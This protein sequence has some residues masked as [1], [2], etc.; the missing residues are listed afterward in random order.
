MSEKN[1]QLITEKQEENDCSV[2]GKKHAC[3][4]FL[5][6]ENAMMHMDTDN[7]RA[8]RT[9][10]ICCATFIIITLIFVFAYT[11]RMNSFL[12]TINQLTADIVELAG[13]KGIAAP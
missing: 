7:E 10:L 13:A 6:H 12:S 1:D 11:V 2:C 5:S 4:S 9:T 8:N 3:I